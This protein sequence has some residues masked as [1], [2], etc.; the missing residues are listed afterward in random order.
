MGGLIKV[1]GIEVRDRRRLG[2]FAM[3][4]LIKVGYCRGFE[5]GV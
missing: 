2:A 4:G 1:V 3:K 5:V